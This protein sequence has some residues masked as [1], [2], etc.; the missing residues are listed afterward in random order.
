M[1]IAPMRVP[2]GVAGGFRVVLSMEP[3]R[4][5]AAGAAAGQHQVHRRDEASRLGRGEVG[6][7]QRVW[8]KDDHVLDALREV[9]AR[10]DLLSH[11]IHWWMPADEN[12][13]NAGAD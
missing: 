6:H 1:A 4:S 10:V 5:D 9:E 7:Q 8:I 12:P 13:L 11:D 2:R 3:R